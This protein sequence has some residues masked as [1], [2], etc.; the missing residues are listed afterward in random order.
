MI[1]EIIQKL[2]Q[3]QHHLPSEKAFK[4]LC[5]PN[6]NFPNE[7]EIIGKNPK[8]A[9][10][11]LLLFEE[12][13]TLKFI[14]LER[15]KYD[16]VHSAEIGLPG[17]KYETQDIDLMQTA[18]RETQEEIGVN[19]ENIFPIFPLSK[20]YIPPSNFWVQPFVGIVTEKPDFIIDYNEVQ[21][22]LEVN[23]NEFLSL[24][25]VDFSVK[26]YNSTYIVPAFHINNHYV[27]GATAMIL[28][29]FKEIIQ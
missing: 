12:D 16:G 15:Q 1:R 25:V 8:S 9:A 20:I 22:I 14:L 3:S 10:V 6:R 26:K 21:T 2:Q 4:K 7:T 27:W 19:P 24:D 29:E 11:L 5:P 23:L 28:N 17:G 18:L 13:K